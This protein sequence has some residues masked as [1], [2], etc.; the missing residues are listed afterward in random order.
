MAA[1]RVGSNELNPRNE[2][3]SSYRYSTR[4]RLEWGLG[5][6]MAVAIFTRSSASAASVP[7][8]TPRA[9]AQK[10]Q[11]G[12]DMT[13]CGRDLPPC[14]PKFNVV[15][16]IVNFPNCREMATPSAEGETTNL[17]A[18]RKQNLQAA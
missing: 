2:P 17:P 6:L 1:V 3:L 15:Q 8:N 14:V 4:Q 10:N 13:I 11:S 9:T 7:V 12:S 16:C 18:K 5:I